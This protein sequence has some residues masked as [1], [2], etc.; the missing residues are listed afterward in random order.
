MPIRHKRNSQSGKD[1]ALSV[2]CNYFVCTFERKDNHFNA[3]GT[4]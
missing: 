2:D 3:N 1:L 4:S